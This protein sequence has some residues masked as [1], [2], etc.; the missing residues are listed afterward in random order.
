M[1]RAT[2]IIPTLRRPDNL[3]RA[4]R[5]LFDLSDTDKVERL[6]IVDNDPQATAEATARALITDAPFPVIYVHQPQAGIATARNTGLAHAGDAHFI[7]FLDDD[8]IASPHW[9]KSLL[10]AQKQFDADV[11]FG[12]IKGIAPQARSVIRPVV[13]T[14]FSRHG[15]DTDGLIARTYGCGN[16]LMKRQTALSGDTPFSVSTNQTGGEDDVLF[17]TLQQQGARFAWAANAWVQEH[18]PPHR[19]NLAYLLQRA[20]ARGQGPSQSAAHTGDI[21]VLIRWMA[22]GLGQFAVFG[23]GSIGTGLGLTRTGA[24]LMI[25]SAEGIGKVLWFNSFEPKLYGSAELKRR[26]QG[27]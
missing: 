22:I 12:P 19:A 13:E 27:A 1:N 7:A 25:R 8:E 6:I 4:V 23:L 26:D 9:L 20:F 17:A 24:Q 16:S 21:A 5:S 15:P 2:I 3:N 11:V 10:D 18:A 14:F